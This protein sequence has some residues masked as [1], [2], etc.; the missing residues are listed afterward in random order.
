[1]SESK[2]LTKAKIRAEARG[3]VKAKKEEIKKEQEKIKELKSEISEITSQLK[4]DLGTKPKRVL[5]DKQKAA[6]AAGREKR[7]AKK[8]AAYDSD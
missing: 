1:M 5:S 4:N 2:T 3:Q 8:A 6:L 7:A